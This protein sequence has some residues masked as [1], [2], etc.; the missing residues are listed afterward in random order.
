M[1]Y[2]DDKLLGADILDNFKRQIV[3]IIEE[4][5]FESG[6]DFSSFADGFALEISNE[7]NTTRVF[8][9]QFDNPTSASQ[10]ATDKCACFELLDKNG[11]PAVPHFLIL[12]PEKE[13]YVASPIKASDLVSK[14]PELVAKPCKGTSGS[15]VIRFSGMDGF[16]KAEAE[17]MPFSR[18]IALSPFL[19]LDREFRCVVLDGK[20]ELIYEKIRTS[21]WKHN[22][23]HGA[24]PIVCDI[25]ENPQ[26]CELAEKT[27]S[28]LNLDFC[29]VDIATCEDEYL[30]I[31]VNSGIMFERFSSVSKENYQTAKN[32][33]KKALKHFL[34]EGENE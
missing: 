13:K 26:L 24:Q 5:S 6:Y 10:I 2:I 4:I 28:V 17:I 14:Y 11:I 15:N 9:Y 19:P 21:G 20:C 25:S 12:A 18:D 22:L 31:E 23:A 8:G 1:Y 30:V 29:A 27:A 7:K 32:I 3:K 16:Q 33:Y 34:K